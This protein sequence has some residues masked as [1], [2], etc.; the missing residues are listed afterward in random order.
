[1]ELKDLKETAELARLNLGGDELRNIFP[2]FEQ[3]LSFFSVLRDSDG[4]NTIT[5]AGEQAGEAPASI[6]TA[7]SGLLRSDTESPGE[8]GLNE[9]MLSQSPERDGRFIVIPNVL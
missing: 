9:S 3:M 6:P 4:G 5:A 7:V 2:E 1:M 8:E